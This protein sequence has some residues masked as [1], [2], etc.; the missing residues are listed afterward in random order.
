MIR[1]NLG[2][3]SFLVKNMAHYGP[4]FA[5]LAGTSLPWCLLT[6]FLHELMFINVVLAVFNLIPYCRRSTAATCFGISFRS[7]FGALTTQW[8]FLVS[9]PSCSLGGEPTEPA[10]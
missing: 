1:E 9:L 10:H 3:G 7:P 4:G 5:H 2:S 6:L 8:V